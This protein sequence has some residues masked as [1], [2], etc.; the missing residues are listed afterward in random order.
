MRLTPGMTPCLKT[1]T[2]MFGG[3]CGLTRSVVTLPLSE[4][5]FASASSWVALEA[6]GKSVAIGS[7]PEEESGSSGTRATAGEEDAEKPS[8][9]LGK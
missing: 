5:A 3:T 1:P 9:G 7:P 8:V 2:L 4:L 6:A